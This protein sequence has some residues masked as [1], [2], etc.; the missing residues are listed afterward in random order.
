MAYPRVGTGQAE[1]LALHI[2][3]FHLWDD[4]VT[5]QV[6]EPT[7]S[8]ETGNNSDSGRSF[9]IHFVSVLNL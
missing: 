4:K 1:L 8:P 5:S 9:S 3:Y 6:K 2:V 7:V